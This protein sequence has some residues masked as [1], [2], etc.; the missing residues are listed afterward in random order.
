MTTKTPAGQDLGK[1]TY[2]EAEAL[3]LKAIHGPDGRGLIGRDRNH[4]HQRVARVILSTLQAQA[5]EI[6]RL[7]AEVA[8]LQQ[9][10]DLQWESDMRASKVWREAGEG[11]E[12]TLPDRTNLVM[13]LFERLEQAER[14]ALAAGAGPMTSEQVRAFAMQHDHFAVPARPG[15]TITWTDEETGELVKRATIRGKNV[16]QFRQALQ[17]DGG[18]R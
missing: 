12:L 13:F 6:R 4:L 14:A 17:P 7:R 10:F 16:T 2:E 11:R 15:V 9:T 8:E 3:A 1:L 5:E 18:G